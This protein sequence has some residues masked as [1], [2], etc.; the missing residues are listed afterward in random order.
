MKLLIADDHPIV[1][2]GLQAILD[3]GG[4]TVLARC[5]DGEE[6]VAALHEHD[7]D[8]LILDIHMPR[9]S[10]LEVVRQMRAEGRQAKVVMLTS[11]MDDHDLVEAVRLGVEAILLKKSAS[12]RL[13]ECLGSVARGEGW[14]DPEAM[15]R[16]VQARRRFD[17]NLTEASSLTPRELDIA[18]LVAAGLRNKEIAHQLNVTEAT[19]KMRLHN[20]YGKLGLGTRT[21]LALFARDKQIV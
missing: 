5:R 14:I 8:V 10:G 17:S 4:F 20:L 13:I 18:R 3:E 1:L 9:L 2:D 15:Q 11:S 19:V 21:E 6:V 16:L 12:H 7:P